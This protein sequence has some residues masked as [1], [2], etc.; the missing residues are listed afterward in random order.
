MGKFFNFEVID[1][2]GLSIFIKKCLT[3]KGEKD[4][5]KFKFTLI[6]LLVNATSYVV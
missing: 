5:K 6:E 4:M 3:K 2:M 1:D